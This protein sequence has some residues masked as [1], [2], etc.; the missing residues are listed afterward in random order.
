MLNFYMLGFTPVLAEF[1]TQL[2]E[3][4]EGAF[5]VVFASSD[6]DEASFNGYYGEQPWTAV[7][8]SARDIKEKLGK[9]YGVSG[10][11]TLIVLSG[12]TGETKDTSGRGTVTDAK[13]NTKKALT[14]WA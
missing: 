1:Y 4:E 7:P 12:A 6:S 8:Y 10:I 3:E 14:K 13:G 2:Q 11:P 5:E 9:K